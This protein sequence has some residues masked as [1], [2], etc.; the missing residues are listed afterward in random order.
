[1]SV[2]TGNSLKSVHLHSG[3][4]KENSR[5]NL[6]LVIVC[7][8]TM[9]NWLHEGRSLGGCPQSK[10]KLNSYIKLFASLVLHAKGLSKLNP[11]E[12]EFCLMTWHF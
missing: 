2:L 12:R 9:A 11:T 7:K 5:F 10:I 8:R 6:C 4:S 1:M 3:F